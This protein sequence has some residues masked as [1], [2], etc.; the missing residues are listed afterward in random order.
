MAL[1]PSSYLPADDIVVIGHAS[2]DGST[3]ALSDFLSKTDVQWRRSVGIVRS[4]KPQAGA[5]RG[6]GPEELASLV[7]RTPNSITY[8][9]LW[10]A[11]SQDL[12]IGNIR[13]RSG[14]Y[15]Q[16]SPASAAAAAK[17]AGLE[18]GNDF[19]TSITDSSGANDYPI[20]SFTWVVVPS[21]FG[22]SE[23]RTVVISFLKWVLTEGQDSTEAMQF[24]RLP[25]SLIAK[26]KLL[27]P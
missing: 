20:A 7:D 12:E 6:H 25:S 24:G 21:D 10:A 8:M 22:D 15:V 18:A 27:I 23:K 26:P 19:R 11:K 4:L 13:N 1:N 5:P 9:E 3:Y 17:T 2:D 14:R 16:A